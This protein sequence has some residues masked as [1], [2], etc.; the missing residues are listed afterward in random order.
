MPVAVDL[1]TKFPEMLAPPGTELIAI[2]WT[3]CVPIILI[4]R[5]GEGINS[6]QCTV[7]LINFYSAQVQ[8]ILDS[9]YIHT[10]E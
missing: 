8:L 4:Y 7:T 5:T 6:A 9:L 1:S 3:L 10:Q 2:C